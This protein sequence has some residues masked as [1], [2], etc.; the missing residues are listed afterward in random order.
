[1]GEAADFSKDAYSAVWKPFEAVYHSAKGLFEGPEIPD[2]PIQDAP[3]QKGE[4]G[5]RKGEMARQSKRRALGQ[6]YLTKGQSRSSGGTL[7]GA[8]TLG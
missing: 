1:M 4:E 2:A 5:I 8:D 3:V 7:G 6:A